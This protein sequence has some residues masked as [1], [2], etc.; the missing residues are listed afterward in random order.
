MANFENFHQVNF[1]YCADKL[2]N[3]PTALCCPHLSSCISNTLL[4]PL[5][6]ATTFSWPPHV[7]NYTAATAA[8]LDG[9]SW[10]DQAAQNAQAPIQG[11]NASGKA[12]TAL[13]YA[14][15]F[16]AGSALG[17]DGSI[18]ASSITHPPLMTMTTFLQHQH[19]I[20]RAAPTS[21][22]TAA[23]RPMSTTSVAATMHLTAAAVTTHSTAMAVTMH[24]TAAAAGLKHPYDPG[25]NYPNNENDDNY[26][27]YDPGGD[28]LNNTS[29]SSCTNITHNT[30]ACSLIS[31]AHN[32]TL[33]PHYEL[34]HTHLI[35][36]ATPLSSTD[37]QPFLPSPY[38]QC[39]DATQ[40]PSIQ[41]VMTVAATSKQSEEAVEMV[42]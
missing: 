34:V 37:N 6:H 4:T 25:G 17:G 5:T 33:V 41:D 32:N 16:D 24:S 35:F 13:S 27:V 39:T 10:T 22:M 14:N 28:H 19:A 20:T 12:V 2:N 1:S 7:E 38:L 9:Q 18:A 23:T 15:E 29:N 42:M 30:V 21:P 3:S 11:S 36:N 40:Q 26:F 8:N 31:T